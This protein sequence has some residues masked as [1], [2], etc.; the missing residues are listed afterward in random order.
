[1]E[2]TT[3][4]GSCGS[5]LYIWETK[6]DVNQQEKIWWM[7]RTST[8]LGQGPSLKIGFG[9]MKE[10]PRT[11]LQAPK[12]AGNG[13]PPMQNGP[14]ATPY[15]PWASQRIG[16]GWEQPRARK[17]GP[18]G[19]KKPQNELRKRS[20]GCIHCSLGCI[21]GSHVTIPWTHPCRRKKN[22]PADSDYENASE[23]PEP[24]SKT[25]RKANAEVVDEPAPKKAGFF[26]KKERLAKPV[27][28]PDS[29]SNLSP[30]PR[31]SW[32]DLPPGCPL[33]NCLEYLPKK[34]N[35]RILS[36]YSSRQIL[37]DEGGL[38][39]PS[40]YFFDQQIC[41]VIRQEEH[42]DQYHELGRKQNWPENINF[43]SAYKRVL[44]M[45]DYLTA[46]IT[47]KIYLETSDAWNS[48]ISDINHKIFVFSKSNSP[49]DY[50]FALLGHR[51]GY[52]GPTG[53]YIINSTITRVLAN[54]EQK[55]GYALYRTLD[56]I[57][58]ENY[59]RF[60]DYDPDCE[61]I[62][63]REFIY[64]VLTPYATT[65]LISDDLDLDMEA[66]ANVRHQSNIFG[67]VRQPDLKDPS[68]ESL[69]QR[70][71]DA[72]QG[73]S[74]VFLPR[75]LSRRP[76]NGKRADSANKTIQDS[77]EED[78]KPKTKA[79]Q[80]PKSEKPVQLTTKPYILSVADFAE[81]D[82][83]AKRKAQ[84]EK[85]PEKKPVAAS[86]SGSQW[87]VRQ[88]SRERERRSQFAPDH[89]LCASEI[90]TAFRPPVDR[91]SVYPGR[92]RVDRPVWLPK[93]LPLSRDF[94]TSQVRE[95]LGVD[96]GRLICV[97]MLRY[98]YIYPGR[99]RVDGGRRR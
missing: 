73:C 65:L 84:A 46:M 53:A 4:L 22:K 5:D 2:A 43:F 13:G 25:K 69:H 61:L 51:C 90:I 97:Y 36:L 48:F 77:T 47:D 18:V 28:P 50:L 21:H 39:A 26:V 75:L 7:V 31:L 80:T 91:G 88:P 30:G 41:A 76:H 66:A 95:D 57:I 71:I 74:S 16:A 79:P 64:F 98:T 34:I 59:E 44:H 81:P 96:K 72:M 58:T 42:K 32:S 63:L 14:C 49:L 99:Q 62:S 11:K 3:V 27:I 87:Y 37:I 82:L 54:D 29:S 92:R 56:D 67:D 1:M 83:L 12:R 38:F 86:K 89:Y 94:G 85:K 45:R 40:V 68:I 9:G 10:K 24:K 15:P 19:R 78:V 8:W 60:D 55:L 33:T 52:Y 23:E 93:W 70:K 17:K 35:A 20:I 6:R